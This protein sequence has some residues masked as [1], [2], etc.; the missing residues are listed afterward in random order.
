MMRG[1]SLP[2]HLE[3]EENPLRRRRKIYLALLIAASLAGLFIYFQE[4]CPEAGGA[5]SLG[6]RAL[7]RL[8]NR[9]SLPQ[10]TDFDGRVTLPALLE[11]GDDRER[12]FASRAAA[13]EGYVV[14]V[15]AGGIEAANCFS[16][17]KRDTHIYLALD[18]EAEPRNRVVVEVT[19]RIRAW[20]GGKGWD[21]SEAALRRELLGRVCRVEG[22]LMFDS[23]HDEEAEN[24][25]PGRKL[26]WRATAWEIHPVTGI[27]VVK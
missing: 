19:P 14:G 10:P 20:A 4:N 24:T 25:A 1:L 6:K 23:E 17:V 22:W 21:W 5:L 16:P 9:T 26:N 15:G 27:E 13:I 3:A 7:V 12:W 8:K 11:P 18:P 2:P